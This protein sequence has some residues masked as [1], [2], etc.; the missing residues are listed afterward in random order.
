MVK[1]TPGR[2]SGNQRALMTQC[3]TRDPTG[4]NLTGLCAGDASDLVR[5]CPLSEIEFG[6]I[7]VHDSPWEVDN[8]S[9]GLM[10]SGQFHCVLESPSEM[11]SMNELELDARNNNAITTTALRFDNGFVWCN[12]RHARADRK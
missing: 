12:H 3:F 6:G 11:Q 9:R 5:E 4:A 10:R 7:F 2:S 8:V 1:P